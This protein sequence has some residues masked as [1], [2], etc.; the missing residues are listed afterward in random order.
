MRVEAVDIVL[1]MDVSTSMRALDFS[2]PA[3]RVNRLAA[4]QEV[5]EK[6][7]SKRP[8]D[9]IALIAFA[10][11]PYTMAPLTLDHEWLKGRIA[12]LR[13]GMIED[14][15]AIGSAIASA[16]NRLRDSP[17]KSRVVVLLTDGINN[18]G[19]ISPE[20]AAEAARAVG[21]RIYTIGAASHEAAIYPVSDPFG[22]EH[23]VRMPPDLDEESLRR[24]AEIS[25]GR[26]F[27]ATD[28]PTLEKIYEEIDQLEKTEIET[29]HYTRFE[30]RFA[31][32]VLA[33]LILLAADRVLARGRLGGLPA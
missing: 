15:T 26:Y 13:T 12:E 7:I 24:V 28:L 20:N 8:N 11:M 4:A 10:A 33:A 6:F 23:Y 16:V 17:A 21:V 31:P 1:A 19:S 9:R 3:R 30:E 2:T 14:G 5:A 27:R 29:H 32:W 25:G 18:M 22:G